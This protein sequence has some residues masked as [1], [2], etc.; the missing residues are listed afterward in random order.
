MN[1]NKD[2]RAW[3]RERS[4]DSTWREKF[5]TK[6]RERER[7]RRTENPE[8]FRARAR[9]NRYR[10]PP[11]STDADRDDIRAIYRDCPPGHHVDHII[12]LKG[13]PLA[14][15]HVPANLQYL[16]GTD[17]ISK[18]NRFECSPE[19]AA[20]YIARGMACWTEHTPM[21]PYSYKLDWSKV[22]YADPASDLDIPAQPK[23][24]RTRAVVRP[25]DAG[26]LD[27]AE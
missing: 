22:A 27:A 10:T 13:Y 2:V 9:R 1:H 15:L 16:P 20:T 5:R 7:E 25:V 14:G 8:L 17:N 19:E 4:T 12:P 6:V 26:I 11:W 24:K 23:P 3:Y 18:G 21:K